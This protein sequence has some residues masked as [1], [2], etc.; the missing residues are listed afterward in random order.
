MTQHAVPFPTATRR[1]Y[2]RPPTRSL[3]RVPMAVAGQEGKVVGGRSARALVAAYFLGP[4]TISANGG[5]EGPRVGR[6]GPALGARDGPRV[7]WF[8]G[9]GGSARP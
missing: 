6:E 8:F 1:A 3:H 4:S 9:C 5:R 7:N 2:A